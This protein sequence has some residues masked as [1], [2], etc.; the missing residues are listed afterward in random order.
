MEF[1]RQKGI[2]DPDQHLQFPVTVIG[3]G[4]IGSP[5][6]LALAK[7]G[8]DNI[9]VFDDDLI[10]DHNIPNQLHK[11]DEVGEPK[12]TALREVVKEFT[13]VKLKTRAERF[14]AKLREEVSG[15]VISGV[16]TM[17]ARK[18]IWEA[19]KYNPA[20]DLYIDA[21]MGAEVCRIFTVNP[22]IP[23]EVRQYEKSLY[24]DEEAHEAPCTERSI[25]YNVF[26]IAG[27]IGSQVKK[28]AKKEDI[29]KEIIFDLV[30][31]TFMTV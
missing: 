5:T 20:V 17:E 2:L 26:V 1:W 18:E 3:C 30:S 27:L 10:E 25:I 22:L 23:N 14:D 21:R 8:C 9:T 16:D 13:A 6:T 29:E 24:S 31:L 28:F 11:L 12:V 19:I 15:V 4:G 7:M